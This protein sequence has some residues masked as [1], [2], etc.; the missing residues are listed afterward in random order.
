MLQSRSPQSNRS[1][2]GTAMPAKISDTEQ[3]YYLLGA[4]TDAIRT[5]DDSARRQIFKTLHAKA[6][7][8]PEQLRNALYDLCTAMDPATQQHTQGQT[9]GQPH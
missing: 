5:S 8:S 6:N 7:A 2:Q 4:L 9:D 1:N 3:M